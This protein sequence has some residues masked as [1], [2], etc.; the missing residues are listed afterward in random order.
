M[1]VV[2]N[3]PL[4]FACCLEA[5]R[6]V[7]RK[8]PNSLLRL[9]RARDIP[10]VAGL[11]VETWRRAGSRSLLAGLYIA[12]ALDAS[13]LQAD[14]RPSRAFQP[15]WCAHRALIATRLPKHRRR[16]AACRLLV[17]FHLASRATPQYARAC[18]THR[19]KA[20]ILRANSTN[21]SRSIPSVPRTRLVRATF[22]VHLEATAPR[23]HTSLAVQPAFPRRLSTVLRTT[24]LV[25]RALRFS[26][27][28]PQ[29]KRASPNAHFAL[30]SKFSNRLRSS[31]A[32]SS[33][34]SCATTY[35]PQPSPYPLATRPPARAPC[36]PRAS[37]ATPR[38]LP[39]NRHSPLR[40]FAATVRDLYY[41]LVSSAWPPL[42]LALARAFPALALVCAFP[43][44]ALVRAFPALALP[45]AF[46][47]LARALTL[48]FHTLAQTRCLRAPA[49]ALLAVVPPSLLPPRTPPELPTATS[50]STH[51]SNT[52]SHSHARNVSSIAALPAARPR[53]LRRSRD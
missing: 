10:A 3:R 5:S 48:A 13:L 43:A 52:T 16:L 7:T 8:Q 38:W 37:L 44:L 6:A 2:S 45:R 14:A 34:C 27:R 30:Q 49:L 36:S 23:F 15:V 29:S 51:R 42:A 40:P 17:L 35:P 19:V 31:S 21:Q 4:A 18:R 53:R 20:H 39:L 46:P 47:A 9:R 12:S 1:Y 26:H 11:H 22:Q 50:P 41:S 33:L 32:S 25:V 24:A 28:I